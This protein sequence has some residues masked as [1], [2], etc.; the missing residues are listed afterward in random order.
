MKSRQYFNIYCRIYRYFLVKEGSLM[1]QDHLDDEN[2]IQYSRRERLAKKEA[3]HTKK[4]KHILMV[5]G[6]IIVGI[7]AILSIVFSIMVNN[8][9]MIPLK[10][11]IPGIVL[12]VLIIIAFFLMQFRKTPGIVAKIISIIL[13]VGL[14]IGCF[15]VGKTMNTLKGM[16]GTT[17][18]IQMNV[19]V[20]ADDPAQSIADTKGY[21]YGILS[22]LDRNYTDNVL[23]DIKA[24]TGE[25][26]KCSEYLL[27]DLLAGA[28]Y[29][30]DVKV[31]IL[32]QAQVSF[33]E[34][35]KEYADFETKTRVL[36]SKTIENQLEPSKP[37][38]IDKFEGKDFFSVYISGIDTYSGEILANSRSDVNILMFANKKTKQ[39]LLL[40]TP[41]DTYVYIPSYDYK[42]KL[43]HAGNN[44]IESSM[45]ALKEFYDIDID[46][47]FKVNFKGFENIVDTLGGVEVY[48][49][50][51]FRSSSDSSYKGHIFN[52]KKGLNDLDGEKALVFARE[53]Q[54]FADGDFQRGRNQMAVI[55]GIFKKL[56]SPSI[57]TS[58]TGLLDDVKNYFKTD[59][60]ADEIASL[61]KMQLNDGAEWNVRSFAIEGDGKTLSGSGKWVLIPY[62][63]SISQAKDLISSVK[64]GEVITEEMLKTPESD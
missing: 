3:E 2:D 28:L 23:S 54:A 7:Q 60:S 11:L 55:Q 13:S 34:D 19:Y 62:T 16:Y 29:S 47:Y 39:M 61:V 49:E 40:S 35:H 20:L 22:V 43:T 41:R 44:G 17:E 50:R 1:P 25:S 9:N 6:F 36:S 57:L 21:E 18:I 48:S 63:S 31:I 30:K 15:Y 24:K 64:S 37:V 8:L 27:P 45:D 46:Y 52:Y 51:A 59:M 56:L 42:D 38:D 12:L 10:Y 58:Y 32:N 26:V 4:I 14:L 33:I 53:R 5:S